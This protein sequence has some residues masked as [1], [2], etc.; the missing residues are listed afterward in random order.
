MGIGLFRWYNDVKVLKDGDNL[1]LPKE[2]TATYEEYLEMK[3]QTEQILEF[4]DGIIYMSPSPSTKH[5]R[6][7]MALSV[8]LGNLLMGKECEV[9]A[10]P[11]D[12]VL[13]D[14][15][16]EQ[17]VV[18][19]DLS[20]ICDPSGFEEQRYVGIPNLII[21]IVSPSN[22]AHDIVFKLNLYQKYKVSEYWII[23]PLQ[24]YVQVFNLNEDGT[25]EILANEK[26]GTIKSMVIP[27]FVLNVDG[28]FK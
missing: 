6:I 7:S 4:V 9:I 27:E 24:K 12:I 1:K 11:Y 3:E 22:Q 18:I 10:A 21:E 16:N 17:K 13:S 2:T 28:V 19:P 14:E 23:N 8:Q 5:Q 25:Y 20:V 26:N 15:E